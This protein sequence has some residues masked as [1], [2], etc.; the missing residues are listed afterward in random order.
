MPE[1][2]SLFGEE[3]TVFNSG[4]QQL[5]AMDFT[6]CLET[7]ER[8][9]K[10]YP[11]GRDVGR[12]LQVA[13][14]WK[15][16]QDQ[17][18]SLRI[19]A[20][21][22]ERRYCL[23]LE[24][25]EA[26]G[27]PWRRGS[28]EEQLQV[29]YFSVIA[30]ELESGETSEATTLPEG[31]PAG[32]VYLL[33]RRADRAIASFQALIALDSENARAYGYLGDA[34][35]LR[36]DSRT[37]RICYREALVMEAAQVD[38]KRLQ[39][40]ELKERL[41]ELRGDESFDGDPLEWFPVRAQLDGIC[42]RRVFRDLEELKQWLQRYLEL[43]KAYDKH[44]DEALV[45]RLFYHAMVLSDNASMMRFIKKAELAEIRRRMKEWHPGLFARYMRGLEGYVS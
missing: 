9:R 28:I 45:P 31:T 18:N 6:G 13:S 8:Y 11:W 1:Q 17:L 26:F 16:R 14:F 42:A 2:L 23:W 5:L 21:E 44:G 30:G 35:V 3:N 43:V 20:V 7:L 29:Q 32:L 12:E 34:Y 10:L 38:L 37:A 4:V 27:H 24:F 41:E 15:E 40:A 25:E 36:G 33:A 22:A 19:D 39:D